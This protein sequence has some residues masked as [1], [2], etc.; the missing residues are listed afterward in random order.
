MPVVVNM[1]YQPYDVRCDRTSIFGNRIA[2]GRPCPRCKKRHTRDATAVECTAVD[3]YQ[4]LRNDLKWRTAVIALDQKRLGCHCK[5]RFC[6]VDL[7]VA[8][9]E[10]YTERLAI[11]EVEGVETAEA[12]AYLSGLRA[13]WKAVESAKKHV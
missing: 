12:I 7:L 13:F 1:K 6:H 11:C 5:P 2:L 3:I 9:V 4:R 10:A 8:F